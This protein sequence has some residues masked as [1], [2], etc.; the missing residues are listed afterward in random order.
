[1]FAQEPGLQLIGAQHLADQQII[2]VF[3]ADF[4]GTARQLS[5]FEDD[6]LVRVE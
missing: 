1:V 3:V 2:A 4:A 6:Y 5:G